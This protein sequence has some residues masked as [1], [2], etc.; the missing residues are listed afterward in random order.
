MQ[1]LTLFFTCLVV[2]FS[3]AV[4][5]TSSAMVIH[6]SR[7]DFVVVSQPISFVVVFSFGIGLSCVSFIMFIL[8]MINSRSQVY[9][10]IWISFNLSY[11]II[12]IGLTSPK[13]LNSWIDV[14]NSQWTNTSH[15][16]TFQYESNCCG[17]NDYLDRSITDCPF[18]YRSGCKT[19]VE[20]WIRSRFDQI[21]ATLIFDLAISMFPIIAILYFFYKLQLH[22]FWLSIRLPLVDALK[23]QS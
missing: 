23:M 1:Y 21:F 6:W 18:S 10:W 17:W 4:Q 9:L 16:Q 13:R 15:T 19:I 8:L 7:A 12:G 14:W 11:L 3:L 5:I 22:P 20:R 2:V